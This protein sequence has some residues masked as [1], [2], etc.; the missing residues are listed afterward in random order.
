[1]SRQT[2]SS[3]SSAGIALNRLQRVIHFQRSDS[4][5]LQVLHFLHLGH[6]VLNSHFCRAITHIS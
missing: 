5:C 6:C 4:E 3:A 1:M 2:D